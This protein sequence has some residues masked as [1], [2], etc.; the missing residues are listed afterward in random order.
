MDRKT[1]FEKDMENVKAETD[2]SAVLNDVVDSEF[3]QYPGHHE[4]VT[5]DDSL[6]PYQ[7]IVQNNTDGKTWSTKD[8]QV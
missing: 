2:S 6:T 5:E 8:D 4:K 3:E 7:E 1:R